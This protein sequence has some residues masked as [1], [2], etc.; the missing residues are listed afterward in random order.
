MTTQS[1]SPQKAVIT[2]GNGQLGLMLGKA[3]K[4]LGIPYTALSLP[5][6][7]AWLSHESHPERALVTFEMEHV[8]DDLL[9]AVQAKGVETFPT[10]GSFR[11][12]K[13]KLSQ[14]NFLKAAGIP[15]SPFIP[16]APWG[17]QCEAFITAN[18][19]AVLKA[20]KGGYDGNGVWL[21]D[22]AGLTKD[23][24]AAEVAAK[25]EEPYLE[26]RIDFQEEVA[27]VVAR[28]ASGALELYPTVRSIQRDGICYQVEYTRE[29]AKSP[30]ALKAGDL[31]R[32]IAEKLGYV[33]VLAVECFVRGEGAAAEVMVNEIAP[34]VHNSGH[35]SIDVCAGSQFENHLR[36]G[37]GLALERTQ[38]VHGAALMTNLLWPESEK[39]FAPLFTKLTCGAEWPENAKLHWYGKSGTRAKRKMGHF[40]VYGN[41]LAECRAE[42]QQILA[43]RWSVR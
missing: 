38:P 28:S 4:K 10:L 6:A 41:T 29:F 27:A 8:D 30:A 19:G 5:D 35:F 14:K 12:L 25:L 40:T 16:A 23:G 9:A 33:G 42:A 34:R 22:G 39:E 36:A 18:S 32:L 26:A 31:A 43:S 15:S 11:L 1:A 21:V 20:G 3:A 7:R 13:S 2:L 37:L 17:P 24:P